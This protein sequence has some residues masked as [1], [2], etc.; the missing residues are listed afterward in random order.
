[1]A[2][3]NST[4][5]SLR[6][7]SSRPIHPASLTARPAFLGGALALAVAL[8]LPAHAI[9]PVSA[10]APRAPVANGLRPPADPLLAI[11]LA[12]DSVVEAIVARFS[13]ASARAALKGVLKLS[14]G[15]D[16][17]GTLRQDLRG[18]RADELLAASLAADA[19][20]VLAV[21][22]RDAP[23][24]SIGTRPTG[25]FGSKA[26]GST[27]G[28]LVYT[29]IVPCPIV[30]TFT[31]PLGRL[32]AGSTTALDARAADFVPQGGDNSCAALL[33]A[34]AA[35]I[36]VQVA[37][38]SPSDEGWLNLWP[39]GQPLPNNVTLGYY[40][41]QAGQLPNVVTSAAIVPLCTSS[42]AGDKEFNLYTAAEAV[43]TISAVGYFA[44]PSNY[45]AGTL[46]PTITNGHVT[47]AITASSGATIGGGGAAGTSVTGGF[48]VLP[49][50]TTCANRVTDDWG[51]V[52]GGVG[53]TA[54][55]A[56]GSGN[57]K[58]FATVGG[59]VGNFAKATGSTIAGGRSN[60]TQSGADWGFV[61]GG[62]GNSVGSFET[63][64]GGGNG[65]NASGPGSSVLGGLF[66]VTAGSYAAVG[67]GQSNAGSG[68]HAAVPG[69]QSNTASGVHSAVL[70]G[71]SNT[72]SGLYAAVG[73]GQGNVA[74]GV[75][76]FV[77]GG[78][79]N[80]A[81]GDYSFVAGRRA[82]SIAGAFI[83][84]G[85]FVF[86]DGSDFDFAPEFGNQFVARATGGVKFVTAID[87][88]GA[89]VAGVRV[90]AGSGSWSS[91]SD[92]AAKKD[93]AAVNPRSVLAKVAS[94]PLYTWRYISEASGAVHMGPTAQDF[95]KAF[96]LGDS[97]KTISSV[98]SDGVA[99][100]AIK[101]LHL[102]I[103]ERDRKIGHLERELSL[104]KE[105][106][107]I[108]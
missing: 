59:G 39:V 48:F 61:G 16:E 97:D 7:M 25:P 86:A 68:N 8:A 73:G 53:N 29:P 57:D 31:S 28:D 63:T 18:L 44:S 70:G 101:G 4:P 80:T 107:G 15:L 21:I 89:D 3:P 42:C 45:G 106:L 38:V 14:P 81:R 96:G 54:G 76:A 83:R 75:N 27:T 74:S 47:N 6:G 92:R 12:R 24:M 43:V 95:R 10:D 105:R 46:S 13:T 50:G 60:T 78:L 19:N 20:G 108:R 67:G 51:T 40:R 56:A 49:C 30:N 104:I 102:M 55:D 91:L 84:H 5:A 69:G 103:E 2:T 1:M 35:A 36:A 17:I 62:V 72:A 26:L 33:P 99:L 34:N 66:N 52:A 41:N 79:N 71:L 93:L 98:D 58:A 88:A 23:T 65:N 11:D 90:V 100:A 37:V 64:V 82:K 22:D 85:T 32:A 9:T 87:G 77:A 94:M